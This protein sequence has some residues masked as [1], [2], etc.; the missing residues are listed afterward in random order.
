M[1]AG[2][3]SAGSH[4]LCLLSA[5]N[6]QS[7]DCHGLRWARKFS[8]STRPKSRSQPPAWR[9][10]RPWRKPAEREH[11]PEGAVAIAGPPS[12]C[13]GS[14]PAGVEKRKHACAASPSERADVIMA[15]ANPERAWKELSVSS[16]EVVARIC[17]S[18][19]VAP[20]CEQANTHK[21]ACIQLE[22]KYTKYGLS[23]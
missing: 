17:V 6:R 19:S 1:S 2:T 8:K 18:E 5:P 10:G 12:S 16:P 15:S 20:R 11:P 22:S 21:Y 4:L 23:T 9:G 7:H 3:P 13:L 14:M